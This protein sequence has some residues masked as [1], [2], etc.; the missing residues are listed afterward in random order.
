MRKQSK[1]NEWDDVDLNQISFRPQELDRLDSI[2]RSA[3]E[4][5]EAS[6]LLQGLN[7]YA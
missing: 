1:S 5:N 6:D 4:L 2:E 7:F 3:N